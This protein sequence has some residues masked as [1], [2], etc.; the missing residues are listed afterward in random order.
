MTLKSRNISYD[1]I[2]KI[3]ESCVY[4]QNSANPTWTDLTQ[5]AV[6]HA[7]PFGVSGKIE[8]FLTGK[9]VRNAPLGREIMENTVK[10]VEEDNIFKSALRHLDA[11]NI[12]TN[13]FNSFIKETREFAEDLEKRYNLCSEALGQKI[14]E[15]EQDL[16]DLISS[17]RSFPSETMQQVENF[18]NNRFDHVFLADSTSLGDVMEKQ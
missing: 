9:F 16:K 12:L 11:D 6:V 3:E 7:Y 15:T 8:N 5:K 10:S 2:V 17:C 14:D 4:T 13:T 18:L 1:S